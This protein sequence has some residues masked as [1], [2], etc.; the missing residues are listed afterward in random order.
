MTLDELL[1][2]QVI[3]VQYKSNPDESVTTI[4]LF[5]SDARDDEFNFMAI[6]GTVIS[7]GYAFETTDGIAPGVERLR[8]DLNN[9]DARKLYQKVL[10]LQVADS[11]QTVMVV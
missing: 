6:N 11:G 9:S 1:A 5:R 2:L 8:Y 10:R 3:D 7:C 4:V